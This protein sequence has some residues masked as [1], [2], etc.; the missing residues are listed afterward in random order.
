MVI[1][2]GIA[3]IGFLGCSSARAA[4]GSVGFIPGSYTVSGIGH[5]GPLT[6]TVVFTGDRIDD[7]IINSHAETRGL[8][9]KALDRVR[10]RILVE[11][12]LNVDMISGATVS[13]AALRGLVAKAVSQAG[14]DP[15]KLNI[16]GRPDTTNYQD[17]TV[18]VVVVGAGIAGMSAAVEADMQGL[19]IVLV[20]QLGLLGG[21]SMRAGYLVGAGSRMQKQ[22]G[23]NLDVE[24]VARSYTRST[25]DFPIYLPDAAYKYARMSGE[26]VDWILNLGVKLGPIIQQTLHSG[27]AGERTG[28]F[29]IDGLENYLVREGV[30]IRLNT[31]AVEIIMQNDRATGV[32][33]V[34]PNG[35]EYTIFGQV[36]LATGGYFGSKEMTEKYDPINKDNPTDVCKGADGSGMLMAEAVGGVL[37]RM[38][39]NTYH[40]L[41]SYYNNCSRSLTLPAGNGALA[42]NSSGNRF[43]DEGG[44][45]ALLTKAA[46]AQDAVFCIMDQEMMNLEVIRE[47]HG[48]SNI[49]EMYEIANTPEELAGK[50]GID[51]VGLS[52]TVERYRR[53]VASGRD[54]EF[55]K[56]P[57]KMRSRFITPPYYGVKSII[58]NHTN[59]GGILVDEDLRVLNAQGNPIPG[60]YA[61]GE[62]IADTGGG[63]VP[64]FAFGISQGRLLAQYIKA[65]KYK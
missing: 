49:I 34:S 18:D 1:L 28:S 7:I 24:A 6:A 20:E 45:Y 13:G 61:I 42:V 64:T 14:G 5:N 10:T 55:N 16:P 12:R 56:S 57:L 35:K 46:R 63:S 41:A 19:N 47:D 58:E 37:T 33:V 31:R 9:T 32:K 8:G 65:H 2:L 60:L 26:N 36:V 53:F 62:A 40:A 22:N 59:H 50:L 4:P 38:D 27:I 52:A 43:F 21:S 17:T 54:A 15:S 3:L 11:Q 39:D 23:I 51:P 29:V 44:D 48:C 25:P 30:D